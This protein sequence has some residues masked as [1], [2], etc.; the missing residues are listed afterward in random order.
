MRSIPPRG[1]VPP[2]VRQRAAAK[3]AVALEIHGWHGRSR[4]QKRDVQQAKVDVFDEG[5]ELVII[6]ELPGA[7]ED[8]ILVETSGSSLHIST[9]LVSLRPFW[10]KAELPCPVT[11]SRRSYRNGVLELHFLKRHNLGPDTTPERVHQ[12][13]PER[14]LRH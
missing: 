12:A 11:E 8:E 9:P 1:S 14:T 6:A 7:R 2:G 3:D 13:T 4:S 10:G 5:H